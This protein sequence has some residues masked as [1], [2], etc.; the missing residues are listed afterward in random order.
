MADV[1]FY[2]AIN[3][4]G[5]LLL[6]PFLSFLPAMPSPIATTALASAPLLHPWLTAILSLVGLFALLWNV[7]IYLRK[8]TS[9]AKVKKETSQSA[10]VAAMKVRN[11]AA[12]AERLALMTDSKTNKD[13]HLRLEKALGELA[14]TIRDV[15]E[16][17]RK[18]EVNDASRDARDAATKE[19]MARIHDQLSRLIE[20]FLVK[21]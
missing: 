1:D 18:A 7:Y 2:Q 9:E 8:E 11:D 16:K 17:Q 13:E 10:I 5:F 6:V 19:T 21:H 3:R 4:A 15:I 12:D 14:E 20:N